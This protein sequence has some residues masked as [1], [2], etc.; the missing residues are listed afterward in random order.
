MNRVDERA[1]WRLY[2]EAY[3]MSLLFAWSKSAVVFIAI[4]NRRFWREATIAILALNSIRISK[5]SSGHRGTG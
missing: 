3:H 1:L 2:R 5:E 4:P